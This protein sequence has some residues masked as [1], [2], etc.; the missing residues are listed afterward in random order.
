MRKRQYLFRERQRF[1]S[2]FRIRRCADQDILI[3]NPRCLELLVGVLYFRSWGEI[4]QFN[5]LAIEQRNGTV[6]HA[7]RSIDID[8]EAKLKI[9]LGH[10]LRQHALAASLVDG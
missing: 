5:Q 10:A 1:L 6:Q 4:F 7:L 2:S 9:R 8:T 3:G